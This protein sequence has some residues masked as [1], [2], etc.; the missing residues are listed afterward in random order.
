VNGKPAY[1]VGVPPRVFTLAETSAIIIFLLFFQ[2]ALVM[3]FLPT[4][5]DMAALRVSLA[6]NEEATIRF[7]NAMGALQTDLKST[8]NELLALRTWSEEVGE[9]QEKWRQLF[10]SRLDSLEKAR[11]ASR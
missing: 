4:R 11:G 8:K 2:A 1:P 5:D 10:E 3:M 6:S 7:S 9:V